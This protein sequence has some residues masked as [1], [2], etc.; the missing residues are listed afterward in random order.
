M[1]RTV[2]A[3]GG[4][5]VLRRAGEHFE[6]IS[7]GVFLM[8]TRDGAS[9]REMVRAC[10]A[11]LPDAR[12]GSGVRVVIAGLGVGFSARRALDDPRVE[13]VHV[14]E[15]EPAVVEWHR[16]PL[17][18]AAGDVLA[19]P[20][21]ETVCADFTAWLAEA[22]EEAAADGPWADVICLDTDNGPDWTVVDGNDRLYERA[23]LVRLRRLLRPGGALAF[24]SAMRSPDFAALL[25]GEFGSVETVEVPAR[26]GEPDI[27]YLV[28]KPAAA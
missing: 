20:R 7:N 8:D 27:V 4:E 12:G 26:A 25:D 1:D 21:C 6:I 18:A 3:T 15:L 5:L 11:A 16:G 23:A 24:W 10:L 14:V 13:R 9:E 17:R 19:D 2:G 22:A 28:R